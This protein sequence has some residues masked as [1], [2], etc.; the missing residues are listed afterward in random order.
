ID[1]RKIRILQAIID[2]YIM[3]ASPV[4]SRS[5][6]KR[7][8]FNL[9]SATIR[10][11]MSDLEEMGYLEQPHTSSGRVPSHKAY[12]LYVNN[13]MQRAQLSKEEQK[14][15]RSYFS[16]RMDEVEGIIK[17]TAA[18]LSDVTHYT[19]MVLPP[20]L[21]AVRLKHI[22]IVPVSSERALV[23][24]VTDAGLVRDAMI[25]IPENMDVH[26]MEQLSHML[27][28]RFRDH[29]LDQIT[30]AD[31]IELAE[32][33]G[34]ERAFF[35]SMMDAMER[36]MQPDVHAVE[37]SG[38]TNMLAFP[39]YADMNKA[40][41]FL[42]AIEGKDTLYQMLKKASTMEFSITIGPENDREE[43]TD[44][45]VVTATYKV[46]DDPLGTFGIIGPTRMHYGRVLSILE[47]MRMSM[48]EA[49]LGIMEDDTK[50]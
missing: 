41:N 48:S 35:S 46:G 45:S 22:Q 24:M 20:Q 11:E 26:R 34:M 42:A 23:I 18:A 5:I 16:H 37:L 36:N 21:H 39:E 50:R 2:D 12:R 25:R 4:G 15:I 31:L 40:K 6:S 33:M 47:F 3:T 27:T 13:M 29:R 14:T 43:L 9:S 8:D 19:A 28:E 1:A 7:S 44:C 17:Q 49:L 30:Q 38:S 10:N 32:D